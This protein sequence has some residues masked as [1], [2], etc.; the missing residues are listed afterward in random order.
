VRICDVSLYS[1]FRRQMHRSGAID[2]AR[3]IGS[4]SGAI[5]RR[6]SSVPVHSEAARS[7]VRVGSRPVSFEK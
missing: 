6:V 3:I 4:E 5:D 7:I 1:N 2:I